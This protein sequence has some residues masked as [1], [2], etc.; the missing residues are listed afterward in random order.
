MKPIDSNFLLLIISSPSGAGKTT[1]THRLLQT[2]PDLSFSVSHTTRKARANEVD[3][4]DYYFIDTAEFEKMI[5]EKRFAEWARVHN[6]YYGTSTDEWKRAAENKKIGMVF[7]IDY[8]GARQIKA[9]F[10]QAVGVFILPPSLEELKKR[11][12]QRAA[13]SPESIKVRFA[14]AREEIEHYPFFDYIVVND[15]LQQAIADLVG[16]VRAERSKRGHTAPLAENLV[17]GDQS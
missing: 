11:L 15:D 13:D 7:D 14:K 10:P 1:L 4:Q 9:K 3:G 17:R 12:E 5:K 6:N 8:Q 16:I 2:F